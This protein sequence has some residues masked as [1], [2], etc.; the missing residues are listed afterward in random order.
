VAKACA[1]PTA[2]T[3]DG[4]TKGLALIIA[5]FVLCPC[6]LPVT[7][8]VLGLLAGGTVFGAFVNGNVFLIGAIVTSLWAVGTWRGFRLLRQADRAAHAVRSMDIAAQR[9]REREL[10]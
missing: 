8:S 1:L 7:L 9:V 4:T 2:R 10:V 3:A 5:S 6:H